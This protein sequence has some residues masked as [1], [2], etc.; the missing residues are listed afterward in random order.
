M[1][2][3]ISAFHLPLSHLRAFY[4]QVQSVSCKVSV[5]FPFR[6]TVVQFSYPDSTIPGPALEAPIVDPVGVVP[7]TGYAESKWLGE[8]IINASGLTNA[9]VVRIGQL[10]GGKNGYWNEK[11]WFPALVKSAHLV[12]CLPDW[13]GVCLASYRIHSQLTLWYHRMSRGSRCTPPHL[14]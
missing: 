12:G 7:A 8:R 6:A 4:S 13:D 10:S 2:S 14:R 5:S 1:P 9:T 3:S 11:E